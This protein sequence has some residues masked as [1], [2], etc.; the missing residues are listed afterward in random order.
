M[1]EASTGQIFDIAGM[2]AFVVRWL[3]LISSTILVLFV[4]WLVLSFLWREDKT[5]SIRPFIIVDPSGKLKSAESGFAQILS[6]Q[7]TQL[8]AQ[9]FAAR[10][11]LSS[12]ASGQILKP[13]AEA[14]NVPAQSLYNKLL[15]FVQSKLGRLKGD[16]GDEHEL[17]LRPNLRPLSPLQAAQEKVELK[18]EGVDV[19]GVISWIKSQLTP[20]QTG[21]AF[22]AYISNDNLITITGD[23]GDMKIDGMSTIYL[24]PKDAPDPSSKDF[25]IAALDEL[26]WR[27]FQLRM[28]GDDSHLRNLP[29]TEFRTFVDHL[30]QTANLLVRTTPQTGDLKRYR[31][32]SAYFAGVLAGHDDW[33]AMTILAA[34]TARLGGDYE[35][36]VKYFRIALD[37]ETR[38]SPSKQ[39]NTRKKLVN[40]SLVVASSAAAALLQTKASL[41]KQPE[42]ITRHILDDTEDA[43]AVE[44]L[45]RGF[46]ALYDIKGEG[47][48]I[49]IAGLHGIPGWYSWN[50][51]HNSRSTA[52]L[53]LFLPW[54]RAYMLNFERAARNKVPDFSLLCWDWT[55]GGIPKSFS[56]PKLPDGSV[57]PL[58]AAYIDL[59]QSKPPIRRFTV[60]N[61]GAPNELPSKNDVTDILNLTTW[62]EFSAALEIMSDLGHGWT[63]GDMGIVSTTSYDPLYYAHSCNVDRLWA[64][65]QKKNGKLKIDQNLLDVV[66]D[67]FGI[68]VSEILDTEQLGYDY[69]P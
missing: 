54:L 47:G 65:W 40:E 46:Q 13:Q 24:S 11:L 19:P 64:T 18:V 21:L 57:N 66:L 3:V 42:L 5:V 33:L 9:N 55:K 29:P 53:N 28:A 16:I 35:T 10:S 68:K 27:L 60:R 43:S 62:K 1:S 61:P 44:N 20:S 4:T 23:I 37:R 49:A 25:T 67:P 50:H 31:D 41:T 36:A 12:A 51:D 6:V 2:L 34:E 63:G 59:P 69:P 48:Y 17:K 14:L 58:A 32:L 15:R 39:D 38:L 45:R 22:T 26:A 56:A 30:R 8:E 52:N 7:S